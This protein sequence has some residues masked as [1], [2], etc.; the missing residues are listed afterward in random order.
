[1][2]TKR[3]G[4][5]KPKRAVIRTYQ[6][7]FGDC[8]LLTFQ[9]PNFERHILID[10]GSTKKPEE[11][12]DILTRIAESVADRTGGKLHVVVATHR[13]QDHIKGF[14]LKKAGKIIRDLNPDVVLQPWTEDPDIPIDAKG[15]LSANRRSLAAMNK[16]AE[17]LF[18]EGEIKKLAH[19]KQASPSRFNE[20]TFI[21]EDN[22]SNKSAVETLMAMGEAGSAKYLHAKTPLHIKRILPGVDIDVLG[23]PTVSQYGG[24]ASMTDWDED[25]FWPLQAAAAESGETA[26]DPFPDAKDEKSTID[27]RWLAGRLRGM[28]LD[29]LLQIVRKLDGVMNNTSLI[30]LF[31]SG[32]KSL[33][34]PGDAQLENWE[35]ALKDKAVMRKLSKVDL[36]KVGHHG[37][38]NATPQTLWKQFEKKGG[39]TKAGRLTSLLSTLEG[40]HHNVPRASLVKELSKKSNLVWTEKFADD[41]FQ[42]TVIDL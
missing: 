24:V 15:P 2:P 29:A 12:G 28:R 23:P 36:Y 39:K 14:G 19:L 34:F 22:I 25:E 1:M 33:L 40:K 17:R 18:A 20:L 30:L 10:F 32:G 8:F 38:T 35:F 27:T 41:L 42:E 6:V 16:M 4:S 13:H 7:G 3:A 31:R 9:Y 37:S 11:S 26:L 21:G 5:R